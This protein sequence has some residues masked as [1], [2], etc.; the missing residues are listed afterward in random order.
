MDGALHYLG[1]L[2]AAGDEKSIIRRIKVIAYEDVGLGSIQNSI[3][4]CMACDA[5]REL[6]FPEAIM[7]LS[8]AVVALCLSPKSDT[9]HKALGKAMADIQS[10]F[11]GEIPMHLRD[12]HYKSAVKLGHVGYKY[13]HDDP[14]AWVKQQYLPDLLKDRKYYEPKER[15]ESRIVAMSFCEPRSCIGRLS[16]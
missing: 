8:A 7:P 12:T 4:A 6:G 13:P 11:V 3:F 9:P 16:S 10:G 2:I 15:G 1:R 5:V 14:K